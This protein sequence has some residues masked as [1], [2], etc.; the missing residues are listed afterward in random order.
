MRRKDLQEIKKFLFQQ[1]NAYRM[2]ANDRE[3][4][5]EKALEFINTFYYYI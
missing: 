2:S 1:I 3:D 4:L 5:V